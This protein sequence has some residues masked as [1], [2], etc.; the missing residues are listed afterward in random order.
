VEN[1]WTVVG[2]KKPQRR[3]GFV[4]RLHHTTTSY[5]FT[6]FPDDVTVNDIYG[7]FLGGL[8]VLGKSISPKIST[9]K[10]GGLGLSSLG[11]SQ[12]QGSCLVGWM[13]FG[14]EASS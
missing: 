8:V 1:G 12:M 11:K 5:F 7:Q 13:I 9:N 4:H 3:K 6:N 10:E 2:G 14:L